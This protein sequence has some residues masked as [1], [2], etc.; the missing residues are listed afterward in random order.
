MTAPAATLRQPGKS[1]TPP[2][3][4]PGTVVTL[5]TFTM[6]GLGYT[7]PQT[8]SPPPTPGSVPF[9]AQTATL[10][11]FTMTGIGYA[12]VQGGAPV[13]AFTPQ[14]VTLPTFTMTGMGH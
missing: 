7:A 2:P 13:S 12:P 9:T 4:T 8:G 11:A 5:P 6:T 3:N 14:S 10:P 1:D